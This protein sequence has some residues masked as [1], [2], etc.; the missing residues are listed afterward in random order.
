VTALS[1][2]V[3]NKLTAVDQALAR[4]SVRADEGQRALARVDDITNKL[5][6]RIDERSSLLTTLASAAGDDLA[7][8]IT[9]IRNQAA[10]IH[11]SAVS[12]NAA[13]E[14]LSNLGLTRIPTFTD[15]LTAISD[16]I[17]ATQ[18]DVQ[19]LR[20]TI[21]EARTTVSANLVT[22]VTTRTKKINDV[23]SQTKFIAVKQQATVAQK[24]QE[25]TN[26]RHRLLRVINFLVV[27]LTALFL[28]VAAGQ[29]LL[30]CVCW[31]H[32]RGR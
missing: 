25:V 17:D 2:S 23:M 22:A 4:V 14:T 6:D 11:D 7:P 31:P 30:I 9:A 13:L 16:R 12:I 21:D 15:E 19:E 10:A 3:N 27:S 29:V 1:A 5:G 24:Q 28:V 18:S 20:A 8:R 32:I 26:L